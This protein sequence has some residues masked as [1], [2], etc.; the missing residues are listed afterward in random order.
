MVELRPAT[1]DEM[2]LAFLQ[3]DIETL[4]P[5]RRKWFADALTA[6]AADRVTLIH[7]GNVHDPQQNSDRRFVL[8]VRGYG[9][10]QAL[11]TG[12]PSDTSWRLVKVTPD[13]VKDFRYANH[14]PNWAAVSG[15]TRL[16]RDAVK[17]LDQEQNAQIN[18]N[19][20]GIANRVRKGEQFP[21]L[22]AAQLT[23]ADEQV[24]IEGHN[25][26]TAYAL[27]GLPNQIEMFIG[28]SSQMGGWLFF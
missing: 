5:D 11:F 12:F 17:N 8:G 9:T 20:A 13:E 23:G 26:A 25:R 16:I 28:T 21:A 24:L 1:A 15:G 14:L 27:I 6:R 22:I 4:D 2:I 10:K 3:A 7:R 18:G 19:V